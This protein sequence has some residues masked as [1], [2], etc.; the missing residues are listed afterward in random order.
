MAI[1][2]NGTIQP[3]CAF[4][5]SEI[6]QDFTLGYK[7]L[8]YDH[9]FMKQMREDLRQD[10]PVAGCRK[11]YKSEELTGRSMRTDYI[12]ESRLGFSDIAPEEPVLTYIDL[13][14]SNVCNNRC[15]MCGYELSTNWY[16]DAKKLGAIIPKGLIEHR[17][18]FDD[19]DFSKL[20]YVKM[21]GGEPLMEQDKFIEI[22]KRCKLDTMN[23][24]ITTNSTVRPNE[25]LLSLLKQCRVARWNLS[26]DAF[27]TLNDFLR[28]G[29][30]WEEVK[31]NID[32]YMNAFPNMVNVNGVV[33]IYN[34]NNFYELE[35]YVKFHYPKSKVDLNLIDG[36]DYMFPK[37][38][39]DSAKQVIIK[40]LSTKKHTIVP[41]VID[42][43]RQEGNFNY[44]LENDNQMNYLRNET[45]YEHNDELY[46][47]VKDYI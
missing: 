40:K 17:N 29:S 11:C 34:V 19:I 35:D 37:H 44:F 6:P 43:L 3:C 28:K 25:E 31:E 45:W 20:T 26:V 27:G 32:W 12:K 18:N 5:W 23:I 1:R 42:A 16:S 33:S 47:L 22:L 13:A 30:K 7:N 14:L 39:P 9:P 2:P 10:K 4:E 38:L 21:I 46:Q 24:L 41:R 8:F 15:R 36:V